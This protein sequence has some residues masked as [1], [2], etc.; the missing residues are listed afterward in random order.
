MVVL[1]LSLVVEIA[2]AAWAERLPVRTYTITDGLPHDRINK[3]VRD[4]RGLLWFCTPG[5]LA[6]FDG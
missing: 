6:R 1:G 3:I 4:S 2:P 5:G